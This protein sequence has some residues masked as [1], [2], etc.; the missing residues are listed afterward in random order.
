MNLVERGPKFLYW[1]GFATGAAMG[2]ITSTWSAI[3]VGLVIAA[4]QVWRARQE[5]S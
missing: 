3:G 5:A 4:W 1:G 2:A